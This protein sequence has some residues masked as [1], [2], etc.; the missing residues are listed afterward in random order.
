[1]PERDAAARPWRAVGAALALLL[2][3]ASIGGARGLHAAP[4]DT[5]VGFER[6]PLRV[7]HRDGSERDTTLYL[8]YPST[9]PS[10]HAGSGNP[11]APGAH[12]LLIFSHGFLVGGDQSTFLTE[13]LARAGYVVAALDHSDASGSPEL[14]IPPF[15]DP[16]AWDERTQRDR[17]QDLRFLVDALLARAE[18]A[19]DLLHGHIDPQAIGGIGHSLGGYT[20]LGIAGAWPSWRDERLRAFV[21]LS[22]YAAPYLRRERLDVKS[23]VMLQG[24]TL[25]FPIT[26]DLPQLYERLRA[27]R[28]LLVLRGE[29]HLAWTDLGC[30]GRTAP[31]CAAGGNP[32]RIV[33]YSRAFF[34]RHLRGLP[35]PTLDAG[36]PALASYVRDP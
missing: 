27:P 4:P 14:A 8:W 16:Q 23:A 2:W 5:G 19:G 6:S 13:A 11:V 30:L 3:I 24:G 9:A 36:D 28:V 7:E 35:A 15:L 31:D 29:N 32:A 12:P 25:D 33:A 26:Q 17:A 21:L 18:R 22:P 34:D 1:M 10:E 20:L